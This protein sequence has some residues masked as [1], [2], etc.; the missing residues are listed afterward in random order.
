MSILLALSLNQSWMVVWSF[1][2]LE[3]LLVIITWFGGFLILMF[4][5]N[6]VWWQSTYGLCLSRH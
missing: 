5:W 3:F 1:L 6:N 2:V 4:D